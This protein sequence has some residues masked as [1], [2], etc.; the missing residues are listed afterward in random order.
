MASRIGYLI[1]L[2]GALVSLTVRSHDRASIQTHCYFRSK[3]NPANVRCWWT[4]LTILPIGG[5]DFPTLNI[6]KI[7]GL[8]LRGRVV[9]VRSRL[10]NYDRSVS[11]PV[12]AL[13]RLVDHAITSEVGEVVST[14]SRDEC[15]NEGPSR[16]FVEVSRQGNKHHG[17]SDN[18][19]CGS[20]S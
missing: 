19:G 1:D 18:K 3:S 12:P 2:D 7:D 13:P 6:G 8:L 16:R 11:E 14:K 10:G 9:D 4:T 5:N 20:V 17:G 15:A